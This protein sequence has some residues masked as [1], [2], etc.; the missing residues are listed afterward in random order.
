M[1][2]LRCG[3]YVGA[4]AVL[5]HMCVCVA[6]L[7]GRVGY[8]ADNR[9]MPPT[10]QLSPSAVWLASRLGSSMCEQDTGSLLTE[11]TRRYFSQC[12]K[13]PIRIDKKNRYI[14][15]GGTGRVRVQLTHSV[16]GSSE[17]YL[18]PKDPRV[19]LK[20]GHYLAQMLLHEKNKT[21]WSILQFLVK[22][23]R[24]DTELG[25]PPWV[26]PI[27]S[28][29]EL[30]QSCSSPELEIVT[31]V[32]PPD[33]LYHR[34]PF[35][36]RLLDES[37]RWYRIPNATLIIG[38]RKYLMNRGL[39]WGYL[40][41]TEI[42][43][44][45]VYIGGRKVIS[46]VKRLGLKSLPQL[47]TIDS[48]VTGTQQIPGGSI[49]VVR[50]PGIVIRRHA[51]LIIGK[52]ST[53][54][55]GKSTDLLVYGKLEIQ[56]T[57]SHP[58][59]FLPEQR[60]SAWGGLAISGAAGFV[61]A[62]DTFFVG[63]GGFTR[64]IPV[65]RKP[66]FGHQKDA[67][68][69]SVLGGASFKCDGCYLYDCVGQGVTGTNGDV[70]LRNSL[71]SGFSMGTELYDCDVSIHSSLLTGFPTIS[72]KILD[73]DNDA[74]Y[75]VG[76][77]MKFTHSVF[78]SA[79]DDCVDSGTGTGGDITAEDCIFENCFHEGVAITNKPGLYKTV[80]LLGCLF[81]G[82]QQ[83]LELGWSTNHTTV[84]AFG[85]NFASNLV[86]VRLG[87][88]YGKDINGFLNLTQC[89]FS[90]NSKNVLLLPFKKNGEVN[91]LQDQVHC[92]SL[93]ETQ[94]HVVDDQQAVMT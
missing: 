50:G 16:D 54:F 27:A 26:P 79:K 62:T 44:F 91:P 52:G 82:N 80:K 78:S 22:S 13:S 31:A 10:E 76:G 69:V 58:V 36:A 55:L 15:H 63:G 9:R 56:G 28:E 77:F 87:D 29:I 39:A 3:V 4:V 14:E 2:Q 45:I 92:S 34:L 83:G 18:S 30:D 37:S 51:S 88:N 86:G 59:S 60:G 7:I 19:A 67:P 85:S 23:A 47:V 8:S 40:D 12:S 24:G 49:L 64:R 32:S 70:S 90:G 73:N 41:V 11:E 57:K 89:T 42:Q 93:N 20:S 75:G 46:S 84:T 48:D 1:L 61:N 5:G 66:P 25:L 53:V 74:F 43:T 38:T 17:H 6:T 35:V 65:L 72:Q 94:V 68:L 33:Q 21:C 81:A 71:L